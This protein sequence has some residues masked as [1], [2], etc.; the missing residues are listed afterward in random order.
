[1]AIAAGTERAARLAFNDVSLSY[2]TPSGETLALDSVSFQIGVGEIVSIVGQSGCGKS[3]LLSLL[4]G[5]IAPTSGTVSIDGQAVSEP[6][7]AIGFMLQQD[8]LF[9]WRTILEN[10][11]L[12]PELRGHDRAAAHERAE[13]L[14]D[15]YGLRDFK[16]HFPHQLSGGMR[17]RA[18]L[19]RTMCLDPSI[20]LL[21]EPFS[22]LDFQTR[23]AI[24]DEIAQI[25]RS[26]GKTAILVTHD[27]NEAVAM[28]DR[29]LVMSRRPGRIKS[30]HVIDFAVADRER[31]SSLELRELPAF[32]HAFQAIW[33]DLDVHV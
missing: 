1:M 26:E 8:T 24:S 31:A 19:A 30:Q 22:A 28:A 16:A 18:A 13:G 21:D 15:R 17:Q 11:L 32:N 6:S 25:I 3:T 27:I 10:T 12:G 20:L 7:A 2:F 5:L 14:L 23:I 4:A 29:V 33:K 9:E